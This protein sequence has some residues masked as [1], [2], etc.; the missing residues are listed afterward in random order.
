LAIFIPGS[1]V[2][3]NFPWFISII[4]IS[5]LYPSAIVPGVFNTVIEFFRASPFLGHK[6]VEIWPKPLDTIPT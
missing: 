3:D 6:V 4:P 5:H 2:N 1:T